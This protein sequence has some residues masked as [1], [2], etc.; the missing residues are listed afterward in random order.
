LDATLRRLIRYK[1]MVGTL[2]G[3]PPMTVWAG[4]GNG[5]TCAAC[6]EVIPGAAHVPDRVSLACRD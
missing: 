5:R 6:D 2:P 3:E 1:I 4:M